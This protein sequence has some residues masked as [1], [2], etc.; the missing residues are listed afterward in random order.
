MVGQTAPLRRWEPPRRWLATVGAPGVIATAAYVL[1]GAFG[2]QWPAWLRWL[3]L[4]IGGILTFTSLALNGRL[5]FKE[6]QLKLAAEKSVD[7]TERAVVRYRTRI[8]DGLG[9]FVTLLDGVVNATNASLRRQRQDAMIEATISFAI[10]LG[11]ERTRACYFRYSEGPPERLSYVRSTGRDDEPRS[12]FVDGTDAGHFIFQ[13][14]GSRKGTILWKDVGENPPPGTDVD[15]VTYRTF[16]SAKVSSGRI[17]YG[18]LGVDSPEVGALTE[19][20]EIFVGIIA[21][22]LGIALASGDRRKNSRT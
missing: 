13:V 12:E 3:M 20:D 15:S 4:G 8:D 19:Q 16:I 14:L 5:A 18:M 1:Q 21:R 6:S 11:K 22:M 9:S 7:D 17:L 10:R 2:E